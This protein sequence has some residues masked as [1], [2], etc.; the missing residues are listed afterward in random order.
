MKH[1]TKGSSYLILAAFTMLTAAC[2]Q[3]DPTTPEEKAKRGDELLRKTSDT[4]K[5]AT[6][7]SF[8]V[9]ESHER[10]RRNGEKQPVTLK[11]EVMVQRP[12]RLWSHA[13]GSDNRDITVTYDGKN[14]TVVGA[15]Q[16]VYATIKAPPT[17]DEMPDLVSERFDLRIAVADYLYSSPYDSFAGKESQGGWVRRTTV[18]GRSCEEV[19]Y[20]MKAVDYTLSVTSAEPTMPCQADIT[21]TEEPGQPV[22]RMVFSNWHVNV[23]HPESQFDGNV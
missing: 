23:C 19:S 3:R 1:C 21:F 7:F 2:G 14:V 11:R 17:L 8:N 18:D 15:T 4:L 9:T 13:T 6:A 12:D 16:K 10:M 5:N 22:S 20:K